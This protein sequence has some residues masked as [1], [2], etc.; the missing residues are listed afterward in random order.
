MNVPILVYRKRSCAF[1][2]DSTGCKCGTKWMNM[3]PTAEH[4]GN[5]K[6]TVK[7][8]LSSTEWVNPN[9]RKAVLG[10]WYPLTLLGHFP[11]QKVVSDWYSKYV[12][13]CQM[14]KQCSKK[15]VKFLEKE[16]FLKWG[17][18]ERLNSDNG[19]QFK[20]KIYKELLETYDIVRAN[21]H[22]QNNPLDWR[23]IKSVFERWSAWMGSD[24][25]QKLCGLWTRQFTALQ[26]R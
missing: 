22:A 10:V 23:L 24:I 1:N 18:L 19:P 21:C 7:A 6:Y 14:R 11:G 9:P 2:K 12:L 3:C 13:C 5:R 15:L 25:C 26:N 20:S 16:V 17:V 8:T 4:V